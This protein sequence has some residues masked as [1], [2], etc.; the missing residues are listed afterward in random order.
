MIIKTLIFLD[1]HSD[2]MKAAYLS[3]SER[4]TTMKPNLNLRCSPNDASVFVQCS[5]S[6]FVNEIMSKINCSI[7]NFIE[8]LGTSLLKLPP[9][10]RPESAAKTFSDLVAYYDSFL[11]NDNNSTCLAPCSQTSYTFSL[12]Y[13]SKYSYFNPHMPHLFQDEF[14]HLVVFFKVLEIDE[15]TETLVFDIV[16]L[17]SAGGGNLGLFI[18]FSCLSVAF[19]AIDLAAKYLSHLCFKPKKER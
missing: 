15:R 12:D 10:E 19:A 14:F 2:N 17:L 18:G 8:F 11:F 5:K 16:A 6:L 13:H 4:K 9:C 1:T 7:Y 3:L